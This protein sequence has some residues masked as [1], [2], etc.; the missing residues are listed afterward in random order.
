ML[1]S[2][3]NIHETMKIFP[4]WALIEISPFS[5]HLKSTGLTF[6]K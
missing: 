3:Y 5:Q 1:T 2:N 4:F 6:W